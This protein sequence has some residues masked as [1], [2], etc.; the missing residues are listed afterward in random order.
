MFFCAKAWALDRNPD[1]PAARDRKSVNASFHV[2]W[3][4]N[5]PDY[6]ADNDGD[7]E[8]HDYASCV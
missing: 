8:I 6:T 4:I 1:K 5:P 3:L 7:L 2:L